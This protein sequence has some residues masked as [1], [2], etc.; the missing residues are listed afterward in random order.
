MEIS[1][2]CICLP[3][4][5][6]IQKTI[7]CPL[8]S[9]L[10]TFSPSSAYVNTRQ[11]SMKSWLKAASRHF[12]NHTF[13]LCLLFELHYINFSQHCVLLKGQIYNTVV[14]IGDY[15]KTTSTSRYICLK[16]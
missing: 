14:I 6:H 5:A 4:I 11:G 8:N 12:V 15:A 13:L 1:M 16:K 9:Q 7:T 2:K 10:A 3:L